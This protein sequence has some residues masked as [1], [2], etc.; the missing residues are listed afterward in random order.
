KVKLVQLAK[1]GAIGG[2][3]V[4]KSNRKAPI[5]GSILYRASGS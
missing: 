2:G 1:G 4:V 3:R 5:I